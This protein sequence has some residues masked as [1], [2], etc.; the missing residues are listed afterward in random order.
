MDLVVQMFYDHL[1]N[2]QFSHYY[3]SAVK[4]LWECVAESIERLQKD[5]GSGCILA[6]CMGLGK[7]LSVRIALVWGNLSVRIAWV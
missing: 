3:I 1:D 2:L 5:E 4:F 6:H 7:S